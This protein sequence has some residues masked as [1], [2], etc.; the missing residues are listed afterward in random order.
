[1]I[2]LTGRN[3][4]DALVFSECLTWSTVPHGDGNPNVLFGG[5]ARIKYGSAATALVSDDI[6]GNGEG[7]TVA[8]VARSIGAMDL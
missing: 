1:M 6:G 7:A 3:G 8:A 2:H 5:G 4:E